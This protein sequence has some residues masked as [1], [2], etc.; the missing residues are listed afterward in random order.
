V[1]PFA[2]IDYLLVGHISRDLVA[3]GDGPAGYA[4]GG[5]VT[6][7]GRTAQA[8]GC[9]VAV[10]TS[11]GPDLDPAALL[12]GLAVHN[13]PAAASTTMEN[14]Y[15]TLGRTQTLH[16]L[17]RSLTGASVPGA[18]RRA[19]IVHLCPIV[20]E[21]EPGMIALFSNSLVGLTPQGWYRS[22][23]D[24]GRVG[25]RAWPEAE[26]VLPLAAAVILSEE[27][28]PGSEELDRV[29]RLAR[30]T[31][32]TRHDRGCTVYCRDEARHFP[33]P[34][35]R[36]VNPTGAGDVFAAA[37]LTRLHQTRGNPWQA[38]EFANRV[39]A[40]SVTGGSLDEKVEAIKEVLEA[41]R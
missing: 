7:A 20:H 27:D 5:T 31:V 38:A 4:P 36:E 9:R 23:D 18:W 10:V 8:L 13:L 12:P 33:A 3:S 21:V 19:P 16:G 2:E 30:L 11:A 26:S 14:R 34:T 39:A 25:R 41:A 6:Y 15:S 40:A 29:R 32:L 22:W 28:L 35:V 24:Q 17:A 1:D 37:Y